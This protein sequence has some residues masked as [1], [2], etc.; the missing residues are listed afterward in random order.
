MKLTPILYI[1]ALTEQSLMKNITPSITAA[2]GLVGPRVPEMCH[3]RHI[4]EYLPKF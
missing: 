4:G 3:L 2:V 1:A